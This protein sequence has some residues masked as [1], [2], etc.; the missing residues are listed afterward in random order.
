MVK[1]ICCKDQNEV[2]YVYVAQK[3]LEIHQKMSKF[4]FSNSH[5]FVKN[6]HLLHKITKTLKSFF[7]AN[8]IQNKEIYSTHFDP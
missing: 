5:A 3:L 4:Q 2:L 6:T 1:I 7:P 8:T